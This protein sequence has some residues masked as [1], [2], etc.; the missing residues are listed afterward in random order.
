MWR[1][2]SSN[3]GDEEMCRNVGDLN[4]G[5][6]LCCAKPASKEGGEEENKADRSYS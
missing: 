6:C 4:T 5:A 3:N 1:H 2:L